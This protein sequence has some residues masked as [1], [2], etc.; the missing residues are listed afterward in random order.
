MYKE[1]IN[2]NKSIILQT[3]YLYKNIDLKPQSL[4]TSYF[5]ITKYKTFSVREVLHRSLLQVKY[6][7]LHMYEKIYIYSFSRTIFDINFI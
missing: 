3:R 6:I 4:Q 1:N 2:P 5:L 7:W